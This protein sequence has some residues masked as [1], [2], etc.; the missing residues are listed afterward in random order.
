[1]VATVQGS[2]G[3]RDGTCHSKTGRFNADGI[4]RPFDGVERTVAERRRMS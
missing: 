4:T 1:M 2:V 3:C